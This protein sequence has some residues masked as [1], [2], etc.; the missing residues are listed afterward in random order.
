[1]LY[2]LGILNSRLIG[3]YLVGICP[4]KLGGY[5]RFNASNI[6]VTPIRAINF[7][8]KADESCHDQM[9]SLVEQMLAL[10]QRLAA[11]K[12]QLEKTALERQIT[13]TDQEIDRLVYALYGLTDDEIKLVEGTGK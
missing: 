4:P 5:T 1:M 2:L 3:F 6:N 13:A 12:T 10:H 7:S 11:A 8:D 9:V